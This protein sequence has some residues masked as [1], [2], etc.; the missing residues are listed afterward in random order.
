MVHTI[1]N[2]TQVTDTELYVLYYC[3]WLITFVWL[4]KL[5]VQDIRMVQI[6]HTSNW[7]NNIYYTIASDWLLL[8]DW[9]SY[10]S[11]TVRQSRLPALLLNFTHLQISYWTILLGLLIEKAISTV[12]SK[13]SL[14]TYKHS[15]SGPLFSPKVF[16]SH[17]CV[18]SGTLMICRVILPYTCSFLKTSVWLYISITSLS[19]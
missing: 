3:I 9:K 13:A 6:S 16:C 11:K 7:Q 15:I 17:F 18:N 2:Q 8:S 19:L 5:L 4:E 1:W 10:P 12:A 14:V